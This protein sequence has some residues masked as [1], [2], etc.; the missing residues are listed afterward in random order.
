MMKGALTGIASV[1]ILVVTVGV[2][3]A[4]AQSY[5]R[6]ACDPLPKD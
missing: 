1:G 5:R 2:E 3:A 6:Y 4:N